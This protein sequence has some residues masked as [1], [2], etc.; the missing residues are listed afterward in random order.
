MWRFDKHTAILDSSSLTFEIDTQ[1]P[2]SGA[3]C[4]KLAGAVW[5]GANPLQIHTFDP[6][7]MGQPRCENVYLR[8]PDLVLSYRMSRVPEFSW[9]VYWR[10][11]ANQ[12]G[13]FDGVELIVSVQTDLLDSDPRLTVESYLSTSQL[14]QLKFGEKERIVGQMPSTSHE[15][16]WTEIASTPAS[17]ILDPPGALLYRP[18]CAAH[19]YLEMIHPADFAGLE[20]S[21]KTSNSPAS[22]ARFLLFDEPLEKGV[23]RRGRLRTVV[24]PRDDDL[25]TARACYQSFVESPIPLTT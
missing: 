15:P 14:L 2:E 22:T 16:T 9:Q 5:Q 4:F 21:W 7:V 8:G 19:S 13:M 24:L 6:F 23:I 25:A 11:L 3:S 12:E 20:L 17:S 18:A 10:A 1:S